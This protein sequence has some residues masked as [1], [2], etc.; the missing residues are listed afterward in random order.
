MSSVT[1]Y[2]QMKETM[3]ATYDSPHNDLAVYRLNS[4]M[5]IHMLSANV[6]ETVSHV[7]KVFDG[8]A[9]SLI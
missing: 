1:R 7:S 3:L 5:L 9:V 4:D 8:L 6:V 2:R